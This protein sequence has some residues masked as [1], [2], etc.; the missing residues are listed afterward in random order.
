MCATNCG[1]QEIS[2]QTTTQVYTTQKRCIDA[3]NMHIKGILKK[4][5]FIDIIA[6][7]SPQ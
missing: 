1:G 6:T 5:V 3:G 2:S 7:C 4:Y